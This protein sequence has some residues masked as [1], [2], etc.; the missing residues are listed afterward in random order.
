MHKKL[1]LPTKLCPICD[2]PFTWRK[3]W[4]KDWDNIKYCSHKCR[5]S[6]KQA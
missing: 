1:H 4:E 6:R 3:K 2:R 5:T